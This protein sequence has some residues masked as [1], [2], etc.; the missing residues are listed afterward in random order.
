MSNKEPRKDTTKNNKKAPKSKEIL[1][2]KLDNGAEIPAKIAYTKATKYFKINDNDV[3]KIR[4]SDKK[5]YDKECNSYKYYVFY[6]HDN[7][8]I[9]LRIILKDFIGYYNVYKK[10][11]AEY[12][13][14]KQILSSTIIGH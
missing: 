3:D 13:T 6:E 11:D 14:K 8:Y 10:A 9:P 2:L 1:K 12:I 4:V 7:K 5:L